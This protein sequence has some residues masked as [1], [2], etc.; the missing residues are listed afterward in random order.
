MRTSGKDTGPLSLNRRS[1][2]GS[3][4]LAAAGG[5]MASSAAAAT[6]A[7]AAGAGPVPTGPAAPLPPPERV[8]IWP[9]QTTWEPVP[10]QLPVT[11]GMAQAPGAKLYYWDTGGTGAPIVLMHPGTGSALTWGYQQPVLARAGFRVIAFSRRGHARSDKPDPANPVPAVED[12]KAVLDHLKIQRCHLVGTAG[13][14][15]LQPD[16]AL[17]YPDRLISNIM[18]CSQGGVTEPAYRA[19]ITRMNVPG[20]SALPQS[21][22]ELG[23]SYRAAYPPGCHV[24]EELEQPFTNGVFKNRLNFEDLRRIRTPTLLLAGG[25]DM[26][27]PAGLMLQLASV[28]PGAEAAVL[29]ESG[30]SGYW[31]QYRAFNAA[32]IDFA[33]RHRLAR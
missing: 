23:P 11:E 29:S 14:S 2:M 4:L 9:A 8:K 5:A 31:E 25:A 30:H 10:P 32:V 24:W 13:G 19:Q 17:S 6:A 15:F 16:F 33:N 12:I 28:I 27:A 21:F 26:I 18:T 20:W 7:P 1:L 3:A 22:R